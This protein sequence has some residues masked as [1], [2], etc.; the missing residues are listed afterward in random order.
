MSQSLK[1]TSGLAYDPRGEALFAS[2]LSSGGG[3]ETYP[4]VRKIPDSVF[5]ASGAA[6]EH[7]PDAQGKG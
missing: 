5:E 3:R 1:G 6:W 2:G 4:V 7:Q